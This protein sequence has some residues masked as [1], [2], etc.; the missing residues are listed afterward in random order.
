[1]EMENRRSYRAH[2]LLIP[3]PSLSH[4]NPLLQ[5]SNRLASKGIKATLATTIF[6]SNTM[7]L[8][9]SSSS[10]VHFETISDGFDEG[11]SKQSP[12]T[13]TY[14]RRLEAVGSKTL[15]ELIERHEYSMHPIDC[16]VYDLCMPWV[17]DVAKEFGI[18]GAAFATQ[19]CTVNFLYYCLH[20]GLL[21]YPFSSNQLS[22]P[23][24][25]F[26]ELND[27]PCFHFVGRL[28]LEVLEVLMKQFSNVE[29]ADFLLVNTVYGFEK[30]VGL[31][32]DILLI[33]LLLRHSRI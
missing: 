13:T 31:A 25:S 12:D 2:I 16:I 7:N 24:L 32:M 30:E 9:S 3:Y 11:G 22:I 21:K 29:K 15:A 14:L 6:I 4:I 23:G 18:L 17:V 10:S 26:L 20:R 5:F 27:M 28:R 8:K 1:M 19:P 33:A